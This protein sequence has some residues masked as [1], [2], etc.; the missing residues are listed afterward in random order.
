MLVIIRCRV[1]RFPVCYPKNIKI[2]RII[3]LPFVLYG[4]ETW[5]QTLREERRL[6]VSE[7][8][9]LRR[10]FGPKR[11]EVRGEWGK[12]HNEKLMDLY[13]SLNILRVIKSRKMRWVGHVTRM[14]DG[15]AY[16]GFW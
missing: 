8:R 10:L 7:N 13:C 14:G 4:C 12:L 3:I 2:H 15:K 9:T 5:S 6:R 16:T 1:F 11:D